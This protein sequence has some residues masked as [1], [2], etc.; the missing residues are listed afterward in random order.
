[1][2]IF[3]Q[4][5]DSNLQLPFVCCAG[6]LLVSALIFAGCS[7]N[8]NNNSTQSVDSSANLTQSA[9]AEINTAAQATEPAPN[10]ALM[11]SDVHTMA[12]CVAASVRSACNSS[13]DTLT[14]SGCAVDGGVSTL[15]GTWTETYSVPACTQPL[16]TSE[17]VTLTS[18]GST[19]TLSGGAT[20]ATNTNAGTTWDGTSIPAT[21]TS[22]STGASLPLTR[23][24][25][26]NGTHRT[27]LGADGSGIFD[28]HVTGSVTATGTRA[29][30]NRIVSGSMTVFHNTVKYKAVLTLTNVAWGS[31]TCC[32]PTSGSVTGALT[33]AVT[34]ATTMTFTSACGSVAYVDEAGNTSTVTLNQCH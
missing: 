3:N 34:G 16:Q 17:T 11:S 28:H 21:G 33:G 31:A 26:I 27:A 30:G 6:G 1:L 10:V 2:K 29:A 7:G 15:S 32:Y 13:A 22:V 12:V 18:S 25:Q 5:K 24:I 23:T 8:N 20:I 19:L 4:S 14:W 9:I